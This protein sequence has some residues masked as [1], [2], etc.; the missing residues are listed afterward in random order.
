M[1]ATTLL[2]CRIAARDTVLTRLIKQ[3]ESIIC[4][5]DSD[6]QMT[7]RIVDLSLL[8]ERAID[9]VFWLNALADHVVNAPNDSQTRYHTAARRIGATFRAPHHVR[10]NALLVLA[11]RLHPL[12]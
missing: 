5:G 2:R 11:E 6:A 7:C 1:L 3:H 9:R 8:S 10:Q 12:S 4:S